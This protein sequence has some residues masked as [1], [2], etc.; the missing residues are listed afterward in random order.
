MQAVIATGLKPSLV[1]MRRRRKITLKADL[2]PIRPT[3]V[4][5]LLL[6]RTLQVLLIKMNLI[7]QA[8]LPV[9]LFSPPVKAIRL[10]NFNW[11][12]RCIPI[13]STTVVS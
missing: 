8:G 3:A 9:W 1:I 6:R 7:F 11:L 4:T 13:M 10:V 2:T 5:M 12:M